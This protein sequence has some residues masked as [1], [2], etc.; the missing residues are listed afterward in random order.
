MEKIEKG[1]KEK[2]NETKCPIRQNG[3]T[4]LNVYHVRKKATTIAG[5]WEVCYM[6][7]SD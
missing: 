7:Q 4:L 5:N 3:L 1:K 6:N 2:R